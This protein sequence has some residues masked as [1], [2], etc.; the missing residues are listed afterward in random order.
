M[1][2]H[3]TGFFLSLLGYKSVIS[4][5]NYILNIVN[6]RGVGIGNYCLA[7]QLMFFCTC[8][9]FLSPIQ[10]RVKLWAIPLGLMIIQALNIFR[11]VALH[12]TIV[13]LPGWEEKMHDYIFNVL[14]LIIVLVLYFKLL[15]RY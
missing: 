8:L 6:Y 5:D 10:L 13:N 7:F 3:A 1:L 2:L 4:N 9:L 12:M 15:L 11:F 14:V